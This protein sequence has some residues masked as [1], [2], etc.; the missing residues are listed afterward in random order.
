MSIY[1]DGRLYKVGFHI[2]DQSAALTAHLVKT[3]VKKQY[4]PEVKVTASYSMIRIL[5]FKCGG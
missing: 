2:W 3:S 5:C 4:M 1:D